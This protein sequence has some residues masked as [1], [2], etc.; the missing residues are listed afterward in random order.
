MACVTHPVFSGSI[1]KKLEESEVTK[2]YVTNTIYQDA[3]DI[4]G[5]T[6]RVEI[7]SVGRILGEAIHRI[8]LEES[9]S[10]LFI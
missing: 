6:S 4:A 7:L 5:R 8:H 9:L 1:F 3:A 2:L 10:S